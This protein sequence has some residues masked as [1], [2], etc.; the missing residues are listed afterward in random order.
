MERFSTRRLFIATALLLTSRVA[1]AQDRPQVVAIRARDAT[2]RAHLWRPAGKG[3]FPAVLINHGSGRTR[4]QLQQLGPYEQQ[5]E[6]LGPVFARHGYLCLFLFRRGVGP[7]TDQGE[8]AIDAMNRE[9]A[10]HGQAGRD[11]IQLQL[12]EHRELDDAAAALAYLRALPDVDASRIALIGHSFGGSLTLLLAEREPAIRSLVLFST[13]GYSWDRSSRLR[14]RLLA[15][16]SRVQAP[17]FFIHAANDYSLN[18]GKVMDE[19]LAQLEKPHRL[20]IYPPIGRTPDD[21]HAFPLTG[22]R[23]WESDVFAF[24]SKYMQQ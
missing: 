17:V 13:A 1:F 4:E 9:A 22:V 16:L 12:L 5:S 6:T 8:S 10:A 14:A 15:S 2:L 20:E 24:L 7:S 18:S 23:I 19:R 21:G 11:S 3:P